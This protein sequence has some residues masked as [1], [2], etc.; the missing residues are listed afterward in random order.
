MTY[1]GWDVAQV[2]EFMLAWL[3][4]WGGGQSCHRARGIHVVPWAY[5]YT[6]DSKA[7]FILES[8]L[9]HHNNRMKRL[10]NKN[11][12]QILSRDREKAAEMCYVQD[13]FSKRRRHTL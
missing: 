3:R 2:A 1:W 13:S 10:R 11:N 7:N 8:Q 12:H 5:A 6:L 4:M 9:M